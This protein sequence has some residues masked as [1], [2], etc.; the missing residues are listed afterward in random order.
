M[1]AI[2]L[3][4]AAVALVLFSVGII[5]FS[6]GFAT[7]NSSAISIASNENISNFQTSMTGQVDTFSTNVN[8]TTNTFFTTTQDEGDQSASSGGQFKGGI[9]SVV[10]MTAGA[11]S[12][13]FHEIFGEDTSFGI[14]LTGLS[15][16]LVYMAVAYGWKYWKGNPD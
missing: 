13:G 2:K 15:A 16:I 1:G 12:V 7:D 8:G 11:I 10:G 3:F 14:F 4:S 5:L 9:I 6:T